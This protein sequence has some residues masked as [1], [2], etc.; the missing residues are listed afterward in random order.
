MSDADMM[1][2]VIDCCIAEDV[3]EYAE[4]LELLVEDEADA[5]LFTAVVARPHLVCAYL[6]SR[7][8][9]KREEKDD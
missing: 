9:M 5:D 6:A 8:R 2:D 4:L 1:W 3:T 7:A